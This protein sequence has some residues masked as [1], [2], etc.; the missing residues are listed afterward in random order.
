MKNNFRIINSL[1]KVFYVLYWLVVA[2]LI[3]GTL[4]NVMGLIFPDFSMGEIGN[5]HFFSEANFRADSAYSLL[6]GDT[7]N[8]VTD[9]SIR[10]R[11][12]YSEGFT[13]RLISFVDASC[14]KLF[15]FFLFKNAHQLFC[16]LTASFKSGSNFSLESYKNIRN[17]G[18]FL[19]GLWVYKILNGILF[20]WFLLKDTVIQGMKLQ[21]SPELSE[22]SGLIVVLV[23]FVFAEVYRSGVVM[24]EESELTI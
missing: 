12:L 22:L 19:L 7:F 13:Y 2:N 18:F 8:G 20:S 14:I 3:I 16:N 23:I 10:I 1:R 4:L 24:Q 9:I 21:F 17:I 15:F 6:G 11:R 5:I